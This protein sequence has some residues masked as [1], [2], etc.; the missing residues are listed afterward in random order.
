LWHGD[1]LAKIRKPQFCLPWLHIK[2]QT[3]DIKHRRGRDIAD[4]I[5]RFVSPTEIEP[6]RLTQPPLRLRSFLSFLA[7]VDTGEWNDPGGNPGSAV[8][9]EGRLE[10]QFL[11]GDFG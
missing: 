6:S 8:L 2:H 7:Q 3:S 10:R 4:G 5:G 1:N 11:I 9:T